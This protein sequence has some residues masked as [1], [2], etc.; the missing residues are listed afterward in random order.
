M[1]YRIVLMSATVDADK[2]SQFFGGCPTLHVPGRTFPVDTRYLEDA[3][4]LTGWSVAE[5][6]QYAR[7][8]KTSEC[9]SCLPQDYLTCGSVNDKFYRNK[10]RSEW[11]EEAATAEEDDTDVQ[12]QD[13]KLEKRY[14]DKTAATINMFDERLI[15]Y[16]LV[17]RVLERVCFEDPQYELYS[18][19][20]LVFMPGRLRLYQGE[21]WF[22]LRS[23]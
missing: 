14:S 17:V 4:E 2:I 22:I 13:V 1:H 15:P 9:L 5:G 3:V 19:A 21:R 11:A 8:G 23:F 18:A 16:D 7:R 20:I 10:A 6:S 12:H